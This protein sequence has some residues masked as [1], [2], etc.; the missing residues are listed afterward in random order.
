LTCDLTLAQLRA[1]VEAC[2]QGLNKVPSVRSSRAQNENDYLA[3]LLNKSGLPPADQ[4]VVR[5]SAKWRS[6][7]LNSARH[8]NL[9]QARALFLEAWSATAFA[10]PRCRELCAS[11]QAAGEAYLDYRNGR[12]DR[13]RDRLHDAILSDALLEDSGEFEL[14][15]L[16]RVQLVHN[17]ARLAVSQGK[18]SEGSRLVWQLLGHLEGHDQT[19]PCSVRWDSQAVS[20]LPAN[21]VRDMF[22]Q[23]TAELATIGIQSS[24]QNRSEFVRSS[25]AHF[26]EAGNEANCLRFRTAHAWI[27]LK[28][29]AIE[30]PGAFVVRCCDFLETERLDNKTLWLATALD[31]LEICKRLDYSEAQ[32]LALDL[33]FER[34]PRA[35]E[36]ALE[37]IMILGESIA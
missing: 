18:S 9:D 8:G 3:L 10:S 13:A 6:Q 32:Y 1:A 33:S 4:E 15:H 29:A 7:A 20:V 11:F 34:I 31:L 17:L 27:E 2:R 5:V 37:R 24:P 25:A 35:F 21:L 22:N 14:L 16:H 30:A 12:F 19:L 23:I 28:R 36:E 26:E